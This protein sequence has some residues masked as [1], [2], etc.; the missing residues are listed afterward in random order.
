MYRIIAALF[1][2]IASAAAAS[3][4]GLL[5]STWQSQPGALLKVLRVDASGQFSG[6]FISNP[7][8]PCPAVPYD[9][10]GRVRG[11]WV[12]FQ[13]SRPWTPDCRVTAVWSGRL[14]NPT[15]L[16]VRW[17]ATTVAPNGRVV[18]TR[19]SEVFRRL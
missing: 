4:Q 14:L 2:L 12:S 15:T 18:R 6:V 3:A 8:G 13:T 16:A 7:S 1:I 5:P 11:P 17:V 19:G 9:M 10:A